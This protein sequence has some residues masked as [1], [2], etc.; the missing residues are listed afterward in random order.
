[1]VPASIRRFLD[2]SPGE[3]LV[4]RVEG[5]HLVVEKPSAVERRVHERFRKA[6]DRSLADELIKERRRDAQEEVEP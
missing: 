5:G 6:E 2:F 1:M 4:G 3:R